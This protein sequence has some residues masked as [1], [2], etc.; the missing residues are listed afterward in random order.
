MKY[1]GMKVAHENEG[2][3]RFI[4]IQT[5]STTERLKSNH[6]NIYMT[7]LENISYPAKRLITPQIN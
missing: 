7:V 3:L 1:L 4:N 5:D 2:K 6:S